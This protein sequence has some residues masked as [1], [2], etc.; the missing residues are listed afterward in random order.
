MSEVDRTGY[1][2][3]LNSL[4]AAKGI[5]MVA[6][7]KAVGVSYEMIRRYANGLA[8]PNFETNQK[9]AAYFGRD[10]IYLAMGRKATTTTKA[11]PLFSQS[12]I[13]TFPLLVAGE[14]QTMVTSTSNVSPKAFAFTV[15]S[16]E[17]APTIIV[18]DVVVV[19]PEVSPTPGDVVCA[20]SP[21]GVHIRKLRQAADGYSLVPTNDDYV[22][23]SQSDGAHVIGVVMSFERSLK[24]IK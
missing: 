18:G 7:S 21:S 15:E 3:R 24:G 10:P 12:A 16:Q 11:I 22:P 5:S 9:I 20:V 19:D 2:Q 8:V 6:L 17:M 1:S 13:K 14:E 4:L 23:L